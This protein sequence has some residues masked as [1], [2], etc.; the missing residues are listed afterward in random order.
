MLNRYI[1]FELTFQQPNGTAISFAV[2]S[3]TG[4]QANGV[5]PDLAANAQFQ[6]ALARLRADDTDED[7]LI[8]IGRTLYDALFQGKVRERFVFTQGSQGEG[9]GIR[10][11]LRT[12][13]GDTIV[14]ALPWEY[15][16]D[17][18]RDN[19]FVLL[20]ISL[21]RYPQAAVRVPNL[22]ATLPLKLLLTAAQPSDLGATFAD[23]ELDA[24]RAALVERGL[25]ADQ[26][27]IVE[28]RNLTRAKFQRLLRQGFHVW[29]FAGHGGF[30][31]DGRSGVLFF[32]DTAG[33]KDAVSAR[34]LG[35]MM[36]SSGVRLILLDACESGKLAA[37]PFRSIAPALIANG[38]PAVVAMQFNVPE[39]ATT[40]FAGAFYESLG[41]ALPNRCL[42][43]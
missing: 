13:P 29:H 19:P 7:L 3:D 11:K 6:A 31:R 37:E 12:F 25:G 32:E 9:T 33:G 38:T 39:E 18:N 15:L 5:L 10:L 22:E 14:S 27:T 17:P 24:V 40:A 43:N 23:R 1:D 21:V 41:E 16:F 34:E 36:S 4:G 28:E 20:D 42:R 26:I 2:E 30:S 35:I 8:E